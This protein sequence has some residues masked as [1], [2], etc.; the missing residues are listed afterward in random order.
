[1]PYRVEL[2]KKALKQLARLER[3]DRRRL[4]HAIGELAENPRAV[5]SRKL[6][7]RKHAWRLRIGQYRVIYD[8]LDDALV[9]DVIR[10]GH[11]REV[12]RH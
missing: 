3:A 9:V 12:Y 8:V 10:V 2:T 6:E 7:A 4:V 11:R 5:G 1:M